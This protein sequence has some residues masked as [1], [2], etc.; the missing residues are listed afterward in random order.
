MK[1]RLLSVLLAATMGITASAA[2]SFAD[3]TNKDWFYSAVSYAVENGLFNGTSATTFS[4]SESMT[5]GMFVTVLGRYAKVD[6][7]QYTTT[8]FNDVAQGAYYA[9]YV[10]WA[11]SKG[12][13]NGISA[14][15]FSPNASITREQIAKVLHTYAQSINVDT[16]K[17]Y[18]PD[19]YY[20][21]ADYLTVSRYAS[22]AMSW[23]VN[24]G[25][26]NGADGSLKP[27][28][29]ASRAQVAAMLMNAEDALTGKSEGGSTEESKPDTDKQPEPK[30]DEK[31]EDNITTP[32]EDRVLDEIG[33]R[34]TGKSAV[35]ENGGYWDYDLANV[36]FDA[37]NDKREEHGL[38]RLAYSL[39]VQE[40]ADIRSKE[41][42][43]LFSHQRPDGTFFVTV[44]R[45]LA[46]E[47]ALITIVMGTTANG[48]MSQWYASE[49]HKKAMLNTQYK[50]AAVSLY[51]RGEEVFGIQLFSTQSPD[52]LNALV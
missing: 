25:I 14:T 5:R 52:V 10:A 18:T 28:S 47:N 46:G 9:P 30:P 11:N 32:E 12:I 38:P 16:D 49:N 8:A 15:T 29:T 21:Y 1:K 34:P 50:T 24:E 39:K 17:T 7:A 22:N 45:Y 44:G 3:V 41:L 20:D 2:N 31:P 19:K 37:I 48:V 35:D 13:V 27:Q 33:Q 4:P 42:V 43:Q 51:V 23:C 40:W 26:I 6:T 36:T